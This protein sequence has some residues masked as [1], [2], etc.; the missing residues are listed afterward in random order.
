[1]LDMMYAKEKENKK[2][3]K[4]IEIFDKLSDSII[5]VNQTIG[6]IEYSNQ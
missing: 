2:L 5:I 6:A 3:N 1:M 4:I